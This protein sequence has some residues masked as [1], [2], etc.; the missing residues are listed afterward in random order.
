VPVQKAD[1]WREEADRSQDALELMLI[2]RT[3]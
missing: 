3:P 2:I 1:S